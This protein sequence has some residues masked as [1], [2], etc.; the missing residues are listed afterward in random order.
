MKLPLFLKKKRTYVIVAILLVIGLWWANS[1]RS[2]QNDLY[3]TDLV[4]RRDLV[5]TVE[6]TGEMKPAQRIELSFEASG[7]LTSVEK[8]V[9]DEV[10]VGE[11]IA[12]LGNDDLMF[13]LRRAGA[14][15][16][17]AEANLRLREAGETEQSIRVSEADVLKAQASYDKSLIDLENTKISS[18]NAIKNAELAVKTAEDNIANVGTTNQQTIANALTNV[19]L[20]LLSSLGPLQTALT[21]GDA[22]VGVD[23]TATNSTYKQLLGLYDSK[24]MPTAELSF[25][26]AKNAKNT[27]EARVRALSGSSEESAILDATESVKNALLASQTFL[28][29][30][31]KVLSTSIAG[32]SL[33]EAQ[34]TTKKATI[35]ADRTLISTQK[36]SVETSV[37]TYTNA[38]LGKTSDSDTY[39]NAYETAVLNLET[40]KSNAETQVKNAESSIAIAKASLEASQA[41]LELKRIGP[42]AVDL[43]P[44]RATLIDAR[45]GYEQAQANVKKAQI[46]APVD[47]IISEIVPEL[48][49]QITANTP[50]IKMVGTNEYDIE[51][52]LPEADVAK[53]NLGQSATITLDAYGDSVVFNGAVVS[54]DPDQ[55]V[56]QDAVYYKSRIQLEP[57]DGM[58]FKPGMTSNVTILTAKADQTIV[59]PMRAVKTDQESG[60]QTVRVLEGKKPVEKIVKLGLRG[61][62]GRVEV[63]DGLSEGQTIIVSEKAK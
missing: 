53:V 7:K 23:D 50:V 1:L 37:Q 29:D 10:K 22:I 21:D 63:I 57:Q 62:E 17:T 20:A 31:Q 4:V 8:S 27:A 30:V 52:L 9:G 36:S 42:R 13:A 58:E 25:R 47:G 18:A 2:S 48:G 55:T 26:A 45:A 24:A 59:I 33:T 6:V 35:D 11:I 12:Q 16:A 34:L 46:V 28:T 15:V 41:A 40:A 49:E 39:Q 32:S 43:A 56:V 14:N 3:E 44:L 38:K 60:V 54:E 5:R 51:I 19:R 61:D